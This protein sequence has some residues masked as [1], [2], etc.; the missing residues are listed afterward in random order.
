VEHVADLDTARNEFIVRSHNVGNDQ[1]EALRR[2]RNSRRHFRAE[3]DGAP[4]AGRRELDDP[5]TVIEAEVGIE[6]PPELLVELLG[7]IN[8]RDRDND[9]S[10]FVSTFATLAPPAA[11]VRTSSFSFTSA[12]FFPS[13]VSTSIQGQIR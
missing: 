5:K 10:T 1:V 12:L 6:P 7:P 8:I 3:L 2:A 11:L 9:P 13:Y 4:R